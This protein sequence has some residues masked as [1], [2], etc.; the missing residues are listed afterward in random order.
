[1]EFNSSLVL[2][3]LGVYLAF[4]LY[5][6]LFFENRVSDFA[7]FILDNRG[8]PWFVVSMTMLATLANA[9]QTLGIAGVNYAPGRSP[10]IWFFLLVNIFI[11]PLLLRP[12]S[13]YRHLSFDT[14]ADLAEARHPG[15]GRNTV[16]LAIWQLG[17]GDRVHRHL[18]LRR[19]PGD[20]DGLRR[21]HV[22]DHS[23]RRG[24]PPVALIATGLS[25]SLWIPIGLGFMQRMLA[26]KDPKEGEEALRGTMK[27]DRA[28]LR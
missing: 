5:L 6:G 24:D 4:R 9:Q 11:Y 14:V 2:I 26:A 17:W 8:I 21:A 10:M 1:M 7:S 25:G 18:L 19:S 27:P 20:R 13:R 15:S 22:A 28:V 16:L 3:V 23:H 12:G